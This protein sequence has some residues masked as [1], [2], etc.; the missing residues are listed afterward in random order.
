MTNIHEEI[1]VQCIDTKSE[2][3]TLIKMI[4]TDFIRAVVVYTLRF[5]MA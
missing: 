3:Q 1:V 5:F 4:K 2:G